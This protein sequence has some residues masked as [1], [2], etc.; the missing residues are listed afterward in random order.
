[1]K[2]NFSEIIKRIQEETER[3]TPEEREAEYEA[4][5]HA[6]FYARWVE[7][8]HNL[9]IEE[10]IDI[11]GKCKVKYESDEYAK[12]EYSKGY[13]PRMSL[14]DILIE[15]SRKYGKNIYEERI[16][17]GDLLPFCY[18]DLYLIDDA[19]IVELLMG[20]GSVIHVY[21]PQEYKEH[22]EYLERVNEEKPYLFS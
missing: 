13:E 18:G 21:T 1:M 2:T 8:V 19:Y 12:K 5:T 3:M 9:S 22:Q 4:L 17:S 20:Q 11:I 10:R 6:K 15:Y 7:K 14:Y 16:K